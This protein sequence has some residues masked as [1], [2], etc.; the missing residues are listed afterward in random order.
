M[1]PLTPVQAL[2][3]LRKFG[4]IQFDPAVVDAFVRTKWARD[5]ADPGR[6]EV[7]AV[8]MIGQVAGSMASVGA[9]PSGSAI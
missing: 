2:A 9:T 6:E 5:L 8:P 4:G 7:R 3:E 1:T